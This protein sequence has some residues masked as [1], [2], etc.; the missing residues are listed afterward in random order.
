MQ[1]VFLVLA[2][3]AALVELHTGTFYLA[4]AAAAALERAFRNG[5]GWRR[6]VPPPGPKSLFRRRLSP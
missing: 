6:R 1:W 3:G 2:L 4:A 5:L